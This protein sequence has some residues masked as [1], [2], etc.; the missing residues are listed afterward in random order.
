MTTLE[1]LGRQQANQGLI[2][3]ARQAGTQRPLNL[4][5]IFF[6]LRRRNLVKLSSS[7]IGWRLGAVP[8]KQSNI[9]REV[10]GVDLEADRQEN[11]GS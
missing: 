6:F 11:C 4:L 10:Q 7:H 5:F 8:A 1:L 3:Q 2:R 9:P